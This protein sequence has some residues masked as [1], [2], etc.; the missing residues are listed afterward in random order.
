M[1]A[2]MPT[3]SLGPHSVSRLIVGANPVLGISYMGTLMGRFMSEYFS[4]DNIERLLLRCQEVG[5]NTWQ[6]SWHEKI[7][8]SL[9]RLR[10]RGRPMH[11]IF[12]AYG[13]H[14]ENPQALAELVARFRPIAILYHGGVADRLFREGRLE[15]VH[16]FIK[17]VQDLGVLAGTSAHNPEVIRYAEEKGWNAD[18]YMAC[19]YQLTRTPEEVARE[20]KGEVPLWGSFLP[21]D[22]ERMCAVVREVKR[23]CLVFKILAGGRR[24]E[25]PEQTAASFEYAFRS[26]KAVDGVIVGMFPRFRDEPAENAELTRRYGER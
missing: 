4:V 8:Q 14:V 9:I 12:L 3:I 11:W 22:P 5:I 16:D 7:E 20:V 18:L 15:E 2:H 19:F 13:E 10:D 25:T 1:S 17:R 6:T 26:I 21:G 24:A 23:P